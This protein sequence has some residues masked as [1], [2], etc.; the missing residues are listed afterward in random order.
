MM[1]VK[2]IPVVRPCGSVVLG[3]SLDELHR[4]LELESVDAWGN[5]GAVPLAVVPVFLL[6]FKSS[7]T[8]HAQLSL[9]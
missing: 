7:C 3:P 2:Y 5:V 1:V 9:H 8:K 6:G 4:L